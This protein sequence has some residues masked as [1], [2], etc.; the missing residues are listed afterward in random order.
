VFYHILFWVFT[1]CIAIQTGYALYF[2]ARIFL[3]KTQ[4]TGLP[5]SERHFVSI[6]ICA[7][8]EALNLKKNLPIVLSQQYNDEIGV[9]MYE[10]LVVNDAST[11]DT[12]EVL[13]EFKKQYHNLREIVIEPGEERTYQGKKFALSRGIARVRNEWLVLTDADCMPSS[14][15]WLENMVT[16]LAHGKEI[17]AGYGGYNKTVGLLNAFIRWETLHTF[18]QYSTYAMAGK[19]YMAV[20]RNL[21]CTKGILLK[22]QRTNI[23]NKLPSGDDDLLVGTM[24]NAY[25]TGIV[26]NKQSFTYS[27]AK[28]N[29]GDWLKQKQRHLSTGK[30]YKS[31]VKILLGLYAIS[32]ALIWIG[33]FV[34]MFTGFWKAIL[35]FMLVRCI[36][37]W[38]LWTVTAK[39]LKEESLIYL[40]PLFDLSWV[41]YNF[42]LAPY[43]LWKNKKQW[44]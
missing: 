5:I 40:F 4:P 21:A 30:Y 10:V 1:I 34:L 38:G 37:Y 24:A 35:L 11:D 9:A 26:C 12:K 27:G 23:W 22:A 20:G 28:E 43:I 6:I 29:W 33:L 2:F 8:N 17:A 31:G 7:K 3:L 42:A 44:T 18:L 13:Q 41:F 36:V 15:S 19:P 16:P 32:H 39:R 14:D 25:N